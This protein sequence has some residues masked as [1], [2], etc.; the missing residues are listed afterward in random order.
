MPIKSLDEILD[1]ALEKRNGIKLAIAAA[2]DEYVIK[3]ALKAR[4]MGLVEPVFVGDSNQIK[5]L[6]QT[7]K[8]EEIRHV[9]D[10]ESAAKMAV[11]LVR[12]GDA[13]M[14]MKGLIPTNIFLRQVLNKESG[15]SEKNILS[16]LAIF[17]TTAY[18]KIFGVTD[19]ALNIAPSLNEK[20]SIIE[21]SV[22]ALHK[23]G[24]KNPKVALLSSVEKVSAKIASSAEAAM[25]AMMNKRGQ[26]RD[27]IVDGPLALDAAI[28]SE[29]ARHKG[30]D[31]TV[32]GDADLLVVPEIDSGNILYKCLTYLAGAKT[33][34]VILGAMAPV[35]LTSRSDSE[36][37]KLYSIALAICLG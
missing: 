7:I 10:A 33:A 9:S 4:D 21:N 2:E 26:I 5:N 37:N 25:L 23:L 22:E 8:D 17:E 36:E 32:A 15:I 11:N 27:C 14:L 20:I 35:I 12:K 1:K 6:N 24:N 3:A 28:S 29:S 13:N 18:H 34:A 19:A 30:I 31:S 16:H